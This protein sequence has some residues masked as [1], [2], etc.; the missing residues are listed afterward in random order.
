[1][2][3]EGELYDSCIYVTPTDNTQYGSEREKCKGVI[4]KRVHPRALMADIAARMLKGIEGVMLMR[5]AA[6]MQYMVCEEGANLPATRLAP[7]AQRVGFHSRKSIEG[8]M[9]VADEEGLWLLEDRA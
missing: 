1:M 7:V 6:R 3:V 8:I 4:L 2:A 9:I 5:C